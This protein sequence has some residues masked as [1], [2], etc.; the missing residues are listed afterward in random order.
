MNHWLEYDYLIVSQPDECVFDLLGAAIMSRVQMSP[1]SQWIVMAQADAMLVVLNDAKGLRLTDHP[2]RYGF[3]GN[4]PDFD[5]WMTVHFPKIA[6]RWL[7]QC[8]VAIADRAAQLS[9]DRDLGQRVLRAKHIPHTVQ[10]VERTVLAPL[11]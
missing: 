9:F 7:D 5:D 1:R 2:D 6:Y 10:M 3:D 8:V 4:R 11:T